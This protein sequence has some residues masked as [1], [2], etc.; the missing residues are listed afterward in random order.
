MDYGTRDV[1]L[2]VPA[3]QELGGERAKALTDIWEDEKSLQFFRGEP[4][5]K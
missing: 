5:G 4:L 1:E 2:P 3:E